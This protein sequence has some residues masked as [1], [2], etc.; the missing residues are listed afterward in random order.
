MLFNECAGSLWSNDVRILCSDLTP[1][2]CPPLLRVL[3]VYNQIWRS[4]FFRELK[5]DPT[6]RNVASPPELTL[7]LPMMICQQSSALSL[8]SLF[9]SSLQHL[10]IMPIYYILFVLIP[11]SLLYLPLMTS[12]QACVVYQIFANNNYVVLKVLPIRQTP[13][14]PQFFLLV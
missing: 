13:I 4:S 6:I 9:E 2:I 1:K 3:L 8:L 12:I 14:I 10:L 5:W 11:S 7:I